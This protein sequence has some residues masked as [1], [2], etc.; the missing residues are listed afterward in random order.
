MKINIIGNNAGTIWRT[1]AAKHEGMTFAA[2]LAETQLN[3]IDLATSI[4]WLAREGKLLIAEEDG[5][6]FFTVYQE[7]YY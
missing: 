5:K 1:L 4:G 2:L 7:F 6:D 3:P